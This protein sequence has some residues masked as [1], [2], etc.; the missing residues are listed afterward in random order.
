M[1]ELA[2]LL[3]KTVYLDTNIFIYAVEGYESQETVVRELFSAR[4]QLKLP[5][6]MA[7]SLL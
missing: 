4:R 6:E 3:G 1:A 2:S 5:S 7:L